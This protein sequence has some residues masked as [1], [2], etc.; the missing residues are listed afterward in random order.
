MVHVLSTKLHQISLQKQ[1][2]NPAICFLCC[3]HQIE[4]VIVGINSVICLNMMKCLLLD[5]YQIIFISYID[6][7]IIYTMIYI[8]TKHVEKR[9]QV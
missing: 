1:K 2:N 4:T 7:S 5:I 8:Y 3:F 9:P 6:F